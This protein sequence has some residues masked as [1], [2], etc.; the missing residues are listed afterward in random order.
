MMESSPNSSVVSPCSAESASRAGAAVAH[1]ALQAVQ[2]AAE[3]TCVGRLGATGRHELGVREV[4]DAMPSVS[5]RRGSGAR[6][7][8]ATARAFDVA[9]DDD[10]S[11]TLVFRPGL[12]YDAARESVITCLSSRC[13]RFK[14]K[15]IRQHFGVSDSRP[16]LNR[17]CGVDIML[18]LVEA[19]Q[20]SVEGIYLLHEQ[21]PLRA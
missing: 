11:R 5:V 4:G 20:R 12:T 19:E 14:Y 6:A 2:A 3:N 18:R 13:T 16:L 1:E 21:R 8:A 9:L 15:T 10:G 17:C 7:A